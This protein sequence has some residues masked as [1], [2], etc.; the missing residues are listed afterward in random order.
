M[1]TKPIGKMNL[2]NFCEDIFQWEFYHQS[3]IEL[4]DLNIEDQIIN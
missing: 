3:D 2:K 1:F 4:Q